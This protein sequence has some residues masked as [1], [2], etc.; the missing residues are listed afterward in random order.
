MQLALD[1]L[2]PV[3]REIWRTNFFE[4]FRTLSITSCPLVGPVD[5]LCHAD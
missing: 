1:F 5:D 2:V 4:E 3:S